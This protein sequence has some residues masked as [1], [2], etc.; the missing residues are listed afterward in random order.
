MNVISIKV[1]AGSL[2]WGISLFFGILIPYLIWKSS[3]AS[4]K[5]RRHRS[6]PTDNESINL[7]DTDDNFVPKSSSCYFLQN[8]FRR[9]LS[10]VK[11]GLGGGRGLSMAN[12]VCGGV[13]LGVCL[14]DLIPQSREDVDTILKEL[15]K[16][17]DFPLSEFVISIGLIIIMTAENLALQCCM[18]ET[19]SKVT[20]KPKTTSTLPPVGGNES[21]ISDT[22]VLIQSSNLDNSKSQDIAVYRNYILAATLSLHSI[23]EGLAIGLG[24]EVAV[25]V[26][27]LIAISVHKA[28]LTFGI[29]L[30]L[31][32]TL[33]SCGKVRAAIFCAFIFCTASPVGCAIGTILSHQSQ[34]GNSI[35]EGK[36]TS[37]LIASAIL[38]CLATGTFIY[39]TFVEVIPNEFS[40][41]DEDHGHKH[42]TEDVAQEQIPNIP[43]IS[44]D[45]T[46]I[47]ISAQDYNIATHSHHD[48]SAH[49]PNKKEEKETHHQHSLSRLSKLVLLIFGFTI[50]SALQLL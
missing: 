13:F 45:E 37:T 1:L 5:H 49:R 3:T 25:L 15:K 8:R 20:I 47:Q 11:V 40:H 35:S 43:T 6:S 44:P 19:Q 27:L 33:G 29:G 36:A 38:Q 26:Q 28:V 30:R 16:E 42:E 2:L 48:H 4:K 32:E 18:P 10:W 24:T 31:F 34:M 7:I 22:E 23:F 50:A 46:N 9:F 21:E 17:T 14:L 12:C 39:V 41:T